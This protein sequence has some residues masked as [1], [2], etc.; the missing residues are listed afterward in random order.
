MQ[1]P[2]EKIQKVSSTGSGRARYLLYQQSKN[3]SLAATS[4]T[5]NVRDEV[6]AYMRLEPAVK[7]N[8]EGD[9][10]EIDPIK[11]WN[12]SST[13][14]NMPA[15]S[16]LANVVLSVPASSAPVERVFSHGGIIF[17]PHPRRLTDEHLSQL[18]YLKCNRIGLNEQ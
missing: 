3:S 2:P 10:V 6:K 13:V 9:M 15:L 12:E 8:K 16:K 4:S 18:I 14:R 5:G 17:R 7:V 11:F 1:P